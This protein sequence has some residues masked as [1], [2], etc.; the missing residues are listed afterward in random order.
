MVVFSLGMLRYGSYV[1]HESKKEERR[2][3]EETEALRRAAGKIDAAPSP[4]AAEIL[5]AN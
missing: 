2:K 3:E 4:D 5:A 1:S